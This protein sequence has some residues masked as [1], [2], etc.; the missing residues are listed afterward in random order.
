M[1]LRTRFTTEM[2]QA[3]I[4]RNQ[5]VVDTIRLIIAKMK[6]QDIAARP[7]GNA[8][9]INDEQILSMLA[10]MIKQRRESIEQYIKGNRPE[11]AAQ[12]QEEINVIET[13]MPAQLSEEEALAAIGG[14]IAETGAA[15]IKDMGK[16]MAA[17]KEKYAGQMDFGKAS[18]LIKQ[19]LAG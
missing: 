6:E 4:A 11:L 1:S 8:D 16:V 15:S 7:A 17:L 2:K 5:R 3:M 9:G 14:I 12:E 18:G 19:K 10:G 13:F